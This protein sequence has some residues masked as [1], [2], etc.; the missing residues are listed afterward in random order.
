M[1]E[2]GN[3]LHAIN[4]IREK[5]VNTPQNILHIV[6]GGGRGYIGKVKPEHRVTKIVDLD[7]LNQRPESTLFKFENSQS[8]QALIN[9]LHDIKSSLE[10]EQE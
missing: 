1:I 6:E 8:V 3:G 5:G 7:E 4:T 9:A 2:F 10:G